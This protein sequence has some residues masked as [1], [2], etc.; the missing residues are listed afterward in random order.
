MA[1]ALPLNAL[2][3]FVVAARHGSFSKAAEELNVTPA[4]VSQ[5]IRQ[6]EEL[7]GIQ[8][9]HRLKKGLALTDAGQSG[10][11]K[12]QEG[13]G[14]IQQAVTQIKSGDRKTELNIWMAPAFA[15]KWLIPRMHKF[16]E[17]NPSIDLRISATV[18]VIDSD[19]TAPSLSAD[20]LKAHNIDVAIRFG[21]GY[22]P[23]CEVDFLMD[24]DAIPLCSPA[25]LK[26]GADIPLTGPEDLLQHTLL[27]D[28]TPYEGRPK[29]SSWFDNAG[30]HGQAAEHNLYFNSV[31]LALA[32][33]IEGQGVVL[34][35]EQL[36]QNDIENG[37]LVPLF[38]TPMAVESAYRIVSLK[39]EEEDPRVVAFKEWLFSEAS[40]LPETRL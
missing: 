34:T 38:D 7:L 2:N 12:L 19:E 33:A 40:A 22:Y 26:P 36:A 23:D 25:L 4:A 28:E 35:L 31:S 32:A 20:T 27:H 8:L 10:L 14:N 17:L 3:A 18:D 6:L 37:L 15:S 21:G 11:T 16:I 24:V 29:W 39:K 5:Q 30:M 1:S 13:F 9:F